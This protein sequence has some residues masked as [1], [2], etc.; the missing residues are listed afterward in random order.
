MTHPIERETAHRP[1]PMPQGP[2][3]MFQSWRNLLFAHWPLPPEQVRSAVP[4]PLELDLH[5]GRAYVGMT[6]FTVTGLRARW[7]PAVPGLSDF[8]E[9]NCRT[10]VRLGDRTGVFF[11]SLDAASSAAVLAARATYRLPYHA[12]EMASEIEGE[13]IHFQSRRTGDGALF[14]A[15]YRAV[16]QPFQ[17]QPGTIEHFL[18]E[19]YALFAVPEGGHALS[20]EIHHAPWRLRPAEAHIAHNTVMSAAGLTVPG[21]AP[22]LHFSEVQDT[23]IWPPHRLQ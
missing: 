12:A 16:G 19:R 7:L 9:L 20:A 8:H 2:W 15:H 14:E 6:P 17:P 4:P 5:E 23:L 21:R 3:I 11:F 18:T 1:W 13:W 10:Y 22:L